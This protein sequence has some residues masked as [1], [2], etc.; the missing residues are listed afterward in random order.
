MGV[1]PDLIEGHQ[2]NNQNKT[3]MGA[4]REKNQSAVIYQ[5]RDPVKYSMCFFLFLRCSSV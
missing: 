4:E 1:G 5:Y 3:C 2:S